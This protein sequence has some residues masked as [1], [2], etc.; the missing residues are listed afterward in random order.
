MR[1]KELKEYLEKLP[2]DAV[3]Y[4]TIWRSNGENNFRVQIPLAGNF[5]KNG[6]FACIGYADDCIADRISDEEL[7][8][9]VSIFD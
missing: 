3:V 9:F 1:V 2:D 4:T 5:T 8:G 7:K 6:K